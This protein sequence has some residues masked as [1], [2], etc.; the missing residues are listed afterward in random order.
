MATGA[1]F[2]TI[3]ASTVLCARKGSTKGRW[4]G[5]PSPQRELRSETSSPCSTWGECWRHQRSLCCLG[6]RE[7]LETTKKDRD[8]GKSPS[9]NSAPMVRPVRTDHIASKEHRAGKKTHENITRHRDVSEGSSHN[10]NGVSRPP[11][12]GLWAR[13]PDTLIDPLQNLTRAGRHTQH[14]CRSRIDEG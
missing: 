14:F 13:F 1:A 3:W 5:A 7:D 10:Q 8:P 6:G 12:L 11:L 4:E 9:H 2:G